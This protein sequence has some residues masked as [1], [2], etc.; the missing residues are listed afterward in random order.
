MP[1]EL[2]LFSFARPL[3][4][5]ALLAPLPIALWL[6]L[7][8]NAAGDARIRR[9]ADPELLPHLI[10]VRELGAVRKWR[11]FGIW[12]LLWILGVLAMAGPRWGFT[13]VERYRP[14]NAVV[15]LLDISRSMSAS[16]VTP[17]RMARARQE[18]D[19]LLKRAYGVRIGLIAFAS[20]AHVITP[21]TEDLSSIHETLPALS[22]DLVRLPG[23]HLDRALERA[24]QL[25]R[26]QGV[27]GRRSIL[28]VSDGDFVEPD[29][30][31]RIAR[32]ADSG[33]QFHALGIGTPDGAQVPGADGKPLRDRSG[34]PV[35][36]ALNEALL[37]ELVLS[38]HGIY[39]R[40]D[41]RDGDTRAILS[42]LVDP[43][44]PKEAGSGRIRIWN[45]Q[46]Y[47]FLIPVFLLL[48]PQFRRTA[49]VRGVTSG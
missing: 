43:G 1:E 10:K 24:E 47:W 41:Y 23:S 19:D 36:S 18:I 45:E 9:Y 46:F 42:E 27:E 39:R 34:Q 32:L 3:W 35:W 37:K 17:S 31:T 22:P 7:T 6:G 16:D 49:A 30:T 8:I 28:L 33:I 5:W 29:L 48:W 11:R 2:A 38:G 20:V 40:A 21:I 25:L 4:L 15:V 44:T 13:D 14:D 26:A 12:A